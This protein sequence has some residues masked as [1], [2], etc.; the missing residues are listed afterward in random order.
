MCLSGGI[1]GFDNHASQLVYHNPKIEDLI[2]NPKHYFYFN[3]FKFVSIEQIKKMKKNR[4]EIKDRIDIKLIN[5]QSKD[6]L[7]SL[8]RISNYINLFKTKLVAIFNTAFKKIWFYNIAKNIYKSI[9]K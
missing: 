3:D 8:L 1:D 5:K 9:F 7:L 6:P 4:N 2:F